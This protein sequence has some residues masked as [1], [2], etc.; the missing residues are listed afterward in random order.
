MAS[1][2]LDR[3]TNTHLFSLPCSR[4]GLFVLSVCGWPASG[5]LGCDLASIS[6]C[7]SGALSSSLLSFLS[8]SLSLFL[9]ARPVLADAVGLIEMWVF[10]LSHCS[11]LSP[12]PPAVRAFPLLPLL[13]PSSWTTAVCVLSLNLWPFGSLGIVTQR[14]CPSSS[15]CL[16]L[17]LPPS[18]SARVSLWPPAC[19]DCACSRLWHASVHSG[20]GLA[21]VPWGEKNASLTY[22]CRP[23]LRYGR[24]IRAA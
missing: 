14:P 10:F 15:S 23:R 21:A 22:G 1:V 20:V 11:P 6:F 17:L 18:S 2:R 24:R 13:A 8:L 5:A 9:S 4:L 12:L 19:M 7:F 16:L 3:P